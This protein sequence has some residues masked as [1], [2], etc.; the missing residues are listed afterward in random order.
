MLSLLLHQHGSD[1][2]VVLPLFWGGD[3]VTW[4]ISRVANVG[5][6][7]TY[8]SVGRECSLVQVSAVDSRALPEQLEHEHEQLGP[9]RPPLLAWPPPRARRRRRRRNSSPGWLARV[10]AHA[11]TTML[12]L[13][14]SDF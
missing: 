10:P 2:L 4:L 9:A 6:L 13:T 12:F 1:L 14:R 3:Q 8:I 5:R 11:A 7:Y